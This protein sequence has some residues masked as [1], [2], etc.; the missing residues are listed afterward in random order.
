MTDTMT[1]EQKQMK[2]AALKSRYNI[3][4]TNGKNAENQ[5]VLRK[6][7]RQIRNLESEQ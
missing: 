2:I 7:S 3:L 6:I 5:G 4:L 1:D